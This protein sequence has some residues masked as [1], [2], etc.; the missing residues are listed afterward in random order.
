M[1]CVEWR[2]CF[3]PFDNESVGLLCNYF[4]FAAH[5]RPVDRG[6]KV[7]VRGMPRLGWAHLFCSFSTQVIPV[8]VDLGSSLAPR[9]DLAPKD[10]FL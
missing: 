4:E 8:A 7:A 9:H 5:H 2:D 10:C 3:N 1:G 6:F